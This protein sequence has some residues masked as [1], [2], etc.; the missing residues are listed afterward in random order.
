M[1]VKKTIPAPA[2]KSVGDKRTLIL[3][4]AEALFAERGF[5]DVSVRDIAASA[6]V[7]VAAISYY[8]GSK[9]KLFEAS[10]A[11]RVVPTNKERL[12]LLKAA[13]RHGKCSLRDLVDA[14]VRPPLLLGEG[15]S[16]GASGIVIMRFLGRMLAMPQEHVF[17]DIYYEDV[18]GQFIT[19]LQDILIELDSE[20]ILRRYNLMVGALIYAMAGPSRMLRAPGGLPPGISDKWCADTAINEVVDFCV[21]GLGAAATVRTTK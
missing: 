13:Q 20:S 9:E 15:V 19:A 8:F 12:A 1:R 6:N 17:L 14:F 10:F 3:D 21:A 5:A 16:H 18:R 7:N 11:R 4:A 2:I